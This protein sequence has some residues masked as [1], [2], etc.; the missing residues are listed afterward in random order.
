MAVPTHSI[1][2]SGKLIYGLESPYGTN[3]AA[4]TKQLRL[5]DF[6]ITADRGILDVNSK[7][8]NSSPSAALQGNLAVGGGI[9]VDGDYDNIDDLLQL[10]FGAETAGVYTLPNDGN[11]KSISAYVQ[12]RED[13]AVEV[14]GI[15][16]P[17]FSIEDEAGDQPCKFIMETAGQD[18]EEITHNPVGTVDTSGTDV[19]H[20]SGDLFD[21]NWAPGEKIT[22]DSVEFIIASVTSTTALVV[23]ST[24]GSQSAVAYSM[25]VFQD[26]TEV[27]SEP[28]RFSNMVFRIADQANALISGDALLIQKYALNVNHQLV[29]D[30]YRNNSNKII[31]PYIGGQYE[32][33]LTISLPK[34]DNDTVI[35]F[36]KTA[37][38]NNTKLQADI[39]YTGTIGSNS[40]K[41]EIPEMLIN[42]PVDEAVADGVSSLDIGMLGYVNTSSIMAGITN[43]KAT[44]VT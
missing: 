29:I 19:T 23:T 6:G 13:K 12:K 9:T 20:D 11:T 15:V 18:L 16:V 34:V 36:L 39:E 31:Q 44:L 35:E 1:G 25:D 27:T 43:I 7:K 42:T 32:I 8:G 21:V 10:L 33:G 22:I 26:A 4:L 5:R 28:I 41:I 38:R 17:S 2:Y 40:F 37:Y 14:N 30:D 24:A 3:P